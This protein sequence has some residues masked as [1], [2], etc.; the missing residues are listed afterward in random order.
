MYSS[1]LFFDSVYD[2]LT[3]AENEG[4]LDDEIT[5]VKEA[6]MRSRN[7]VSVDPDQLPLQLTARLI[8]AGH[9]DLP[10]MK[11]L[12]EQCLDPP[13]RCLTTIQGRFGIARLFPAKGKSHVTMTSQSLITWFYWHANVGFWSTVPKSTCPACL[14]KDQSA[15]CARHF[16][17]RFQKEMYSCFRHHP[18]KVYFVKGKSMDK[19]GTCF[20]FCFSGD[21]SLFW[22]PKHENSSFI[23]IKS[24]R[25][26][27][28]LTHSSFINGNPNNFAKSTQSACGIPLL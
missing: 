20:F 19:N 2:D 17:D 3:L 5:A 28:W 25:I 8:E 23:S 11:V 9:R 10:H 6:L 13:F 16:G 15:D 4:L 21:A 22:K 24:T 27:P 14:G 26:K 7:V 12:L 1:C 18:S